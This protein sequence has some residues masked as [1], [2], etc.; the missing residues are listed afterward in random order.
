MKEFG[1]GKTYWM[2]SVCDYNCIWYCMV[3]T[4]TEK[5]VTLKIEGDRT[6]VRCKVTEWD[7]SEHCSPLGKYSMAPVLS[8]ENERNKMREEI[9]EILMRRD[10]MSE[11]EALKKIAA[12]KDQFQEYLI[13]DDIDSA[14]YICEEFFGLEPDYIFELM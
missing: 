3:V 1:V 13:E 6:V 9:K 4:R 8:A 7:D 2:R 10:G 12:A 11:M 14:D 5:S